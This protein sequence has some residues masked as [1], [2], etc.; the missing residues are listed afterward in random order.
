L[1][2]DA[3]YYEVKTYETFEET[4]EIEEVVDDTEAATPI[5]H[6]D[7]TEDKEV[8][9]LAAN[10][11][12]PGLEGVDKRGEEVVEPVKD[13]VVLDE[14]EESVRE[15]A[16]THKTTLDAEPAVSNGTPPRL[17][18]YKISGLPASLDD[19]TIVGLVHEMKAYPVF[20]NQTLGL[21]DLEEEPDILVFLV[22]LV[23]EDP[24]YTKLLMWTVYKSEEDGIVNQSTKNARCILET[25]G[26]QFQETV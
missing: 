17:R 20:D 12:A 2:A 7:Q 23:F 10:A 15:N 1:P 3:W 13:D 5:I 26:I 6:E 22:D 11:K 18:E 9:A 24:D 25:A 8:L 14:C 16:T 21:M 4:E 19:L